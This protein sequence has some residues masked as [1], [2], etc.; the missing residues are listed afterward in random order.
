M[1]PTI[2]VRDSLPVT[3]FRLFA[4][5]LGFNTSSNNSDLFNSGICTHTTNW[6]TIPFADIQGLKGNIAG[7]HEFHL[8]LKCDEQMI[9]IKYFRFWEACREIEASPH[10]GGLAP[11]ISFSALSC[12]FSPSI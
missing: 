8:K 5:Q 11:A 9:S 6:P 12:T 10:P 7:E 2:V 1:L 4:V 3:R